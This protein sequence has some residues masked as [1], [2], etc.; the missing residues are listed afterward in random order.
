MSDFFGIYNVNMPLGLPPSE[1]VLPAEK[2]NNT[3]IPF[4]A[5]VWK[6][7]VME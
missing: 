1:K 7:V 3:D 2:N 5:H 6:N 4:T